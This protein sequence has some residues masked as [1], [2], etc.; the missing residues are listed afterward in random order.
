MNSSILQDTQSHTTNLESS[1]CSA[2][3][4]MLANDLGITCEEYLSYV[5]TF[6]DNAYNDKL[7]LIFVFEII[8]CIALTCWVN[9][10]RR[11]RRKSMID[12]EAF[13]YEY[14]KQFHEKQEQR[15]AY[16]RGYTDEHPEWMILVWNYYKR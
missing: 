4:E 7:I 12:Q 1:A 8:F 9:K 15:K 11:E 13:Y 5:Q 2:S 16:I 6:L 3:V 10:G 14:I